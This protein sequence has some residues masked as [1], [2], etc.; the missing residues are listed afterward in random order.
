MAE[1]IDLS[2]IPTVQDGEDF[3]GEVI[4]LS[5]IPVVGDD[6]IGQEEVIDLDI[7]QVQVG[8][9]EIQEVAKPSFMDLLK[10]RSILGVSNT[11]SARPKDNLSNVQ[12]FIP[13]ARLDT[14]GNVEVPNPETGI[15]EPLVNQAGITG[16]FAQGVAESLEPITQ[17][18]IESIGGL[19][20][21]AIGAP[22]GPGAAITAAG[23]VLLASQ[24]GAQAFENTARALGVEDSRSLIEIS[25]DMAIEGIFE[26]G[27]PS[28]IQKAGEVLV[29][30]PINMGKFAKEK[31][32]NFLNKF[33]TLSDPEKGIVV[34][35]LDGIKKGVATKNSK[36]V[37]DR[38]VRNGIP[39]EAALELIY[40][41]N[42]VRKVIET[43]SK[44]P[45]S[46]LDTVLEKNKN[47]VID[48]IISTP[49]NIDFDGKSIKIKTPQTVGTR[50]QEGANKFKIRSSKIQGGLRKKVTEGIEKE[51]V[52]IDDLI[53]EI[54]SNSE[55]YKNIPNT[56]TLLNLP[57]YKKIAVDLKNID[58]AASQIPTGTRIDLSKAGSETRKAL[59]EMIGKGKIKEAERFIIGADDL[60]GS[61]KKKSLDFNELINL[62]QAV[63]GTI[64]DNS[65]NGLR[66][67]SQEMQPMVQLERK[68]RDKVNT[69]LQSNHPD[70]HKIKIEADKQWIRDTEIIEKGLDKIAS[71]GVTPGQAYTAALANSDIEDTRLINIKR[72]V[73]KVD[74]KLWPEF[75]VSVI[76]RFGKSNTNSGFDLNTWS[77]NYNKLSNESKG[78]LFGDVP[79]LKK[80]LEDF[81]NIIALYK[82]SG[83]DLN[84][85][86]T[87]TTLPY[88]P[89]FMM[90]ALTTTQ[91]LLTS[92]ATHLTGRLLKNKDFMDFL[93]DGLDPKKIKTIINDQGE[94]A[95]KYAEKFK[96][97]KHILRLGVIARN[98]ADIREDLK[99]FMR[100]LDES[101]RDENLKEVFKDEN[102]KSIDINSDRRIPNP[103]KRRIEKSS[104]RPQPHGTAIGVRG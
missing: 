77:K 69:F 7:P 64:Q 81:S 13:N 103:R 17:A 14:S 45:F 41:N 51:K 75:S 23:G 95:F 56:N 32:L 40:G 38:F 82:E 60:N 99:V 90:K 88:L 89:G 80:K 92:G 2:S 76:D 93:V 4:D 34:S 36:E 67:T 84:T 21:K 72:A 18:G 37:V 101:M 43:V 8:G 94:M 30:A 15:F 39:R 1:E 91:G 47:R 53:D 16:D 65:L 71:R 31:T 44:S 3:E 54:N 79:G 100:G 42:T 102:L 78:T 87:A 59:S 104:G 74:K 28:A 63:K 12:S 62:H 49:Y 9:D 73:N 20:G 86:R 58:N 5:Q 52:V 70:R 50:L 55:S 57:E 29:K 66:K 24:L 98:N 33:I 27:I 97:S 96:P 68:I 35:T 19:M 48:E 11:L 85:S 22:T 61:L 10:A 25:E 26:M 46:N 6:Q 83:K